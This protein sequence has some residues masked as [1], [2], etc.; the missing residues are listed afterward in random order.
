M[1]MCNA[2]AVAIYLEAKNW[3]T[4]F[5]HLAGILNPQY[6]RVMRLRWVDNL[7]LL[8]VMN[9][10]LPEDGQHQI[11]KIILKMYQPFTLKI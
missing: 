6:V 5:S 9:N 8:I 1:N 2:T 7:C 10:P 4:V 11:R 3:Q